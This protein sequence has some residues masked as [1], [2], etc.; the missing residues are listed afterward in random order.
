MRSI[1][2][3]SVDSPNFAERSYGQLNRKMQG[4]GIIKK[5]RA[6]RYHMKGSVKQVLKKE[7]KQHLQLKSKVRGMSS[8]FL[9]IPSLG[10]QEY[11]LPSFCSPHQV[12]WN[13]SSSSSGTALN[14]RA[15]R[16]SLPL[17]FVSGFRLLYMSGCPLHTEQTPSKAS[18]A[19]GLLI[20]AR[21]HMPF[22]PSGGL[23]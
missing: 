4:D 21:G 8:C 18:S 2:S 9:F 15:L 1:I 10:A 16:A 22:P 20:R 7:K 3:V 5:L 11:N 19:P 14:S 6:N 23:F 17:A 13:G 12:F